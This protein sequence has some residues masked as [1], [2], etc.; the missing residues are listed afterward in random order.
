MEMD[1]DLEKLNSYLDTTRPNYL[2]NSEIEK[3]NNVNS[4]GILI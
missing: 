1:C 4:Q 3:E 2:H